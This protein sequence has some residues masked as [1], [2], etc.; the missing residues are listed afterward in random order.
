MEYSNEYDINNKK[1]FGNRN[2]E[3]QIEKYKEEKPIIDKTEEHQKDEIKEE[4]DKKEQN[5][6]EIIEN[7]ENIIDTDKIQLEVS[8]TKGETKVNEGDTLYE[9]EFVKY[10]VKIKNLLAKRC[11]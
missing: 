8:P 4:G 6:E 7:I 1:E 2:I 5:Q 10:N 3:I 11:R 9:G